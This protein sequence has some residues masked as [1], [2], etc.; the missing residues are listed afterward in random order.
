MLRDRDNHRNQRESRRVERFAD[1][2]VRMKRRLRVGRDTPK[3]VDFIVI[4][5]M[6]TDRRTLARQ[7]SGYMDVCGCGGL[8]FWSVG[9]NVVKRRL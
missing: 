6:R 7:S 3:D 1:N 4:R 2:G 5:S 8:V 9:M